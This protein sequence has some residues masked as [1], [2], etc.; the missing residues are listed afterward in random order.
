M[1][2]LGRA[3]MLSALRGEVQPPGLECP[4]VPAAH[5]TVVSTPPSARRVAQFVADESGLAR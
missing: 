5:P 4:G 3:S 2:Q 1:A